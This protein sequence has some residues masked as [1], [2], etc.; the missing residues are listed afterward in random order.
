MN[1][2]DQRFSWSEPVIRLRSRAYCQCSTTADQSPCTC[3]YLLCVFA[4]GCAIK[5]ATVIVHL[6][7]SHSHSYMHTNLWKRTPLVHGTKCFIVCI[8]EGF[9]QYLEFAITKHGMTQ[10]SPDHILCT[11]AQSRCSSKQKKFC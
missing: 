2:P 7:V 4:P 5:I 6:Y 3:T 8:S 1:G 9:V 11:L 10:G